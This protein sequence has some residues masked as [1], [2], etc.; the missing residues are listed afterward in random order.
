M[1]KGLTHVLLQKT[2]N[3]EYDHSFKQW[4][5]DFLQRT[6]MY[7]VLGVVGKSA[8]SG[9]I[10][11]RFT[12]TE[13][14]LTK[15]NMTKARW[16][17]FALEELGMQP[18]DFA[19]EM[20]FNGQMLSK[21]EIINN[22]A[23]GLLFEFVPGVKSIVMGKVWKVNGEVKTRQEVEKMLEENKQTIQEQIDA[24]FDQR[25]SPEYQQLRDQMVRQE[26]TTGRSRERWL[27]QAEQF[28]SQLLDGQI[29]LREIDESLLP[30]ELIVLR[31]AAS[32][33]ELSP[34]QIRAVQKLIGTT[35][36][37]YR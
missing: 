34:E 16:T 13:G 5:V 28:E 15:V 12:S 32:F 25:N 9:R 17:S 29:A 18:A 14:N 6:A 4:T 26:V 7:S 27:S 1:N 30:A 21:E 10:A 8:E 19:I 31:D 36:D 37:S 23:M 24:Q 11:R 3:G 33:D 2:Y 22:I 35:P 20:S